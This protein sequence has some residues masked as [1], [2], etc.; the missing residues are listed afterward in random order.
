MTNLRTLMSTACLMMFASPVLAQPQAGLAPFPTDEYSYH[1]S[2]G[3]EPPPVNLPSDLGRR[4]GAVLVFRAGTHSGVGAATP[5]CD[6]ECGTQPE[7]EGFDEHPS[8]VLSSEWLTSLS[9]N[10]RFGAGL[11]MI[12]TLSTQMDGE[13]YELGTVVGGDLVFEGLIDLSPKIA[14]TLRGSAGLSLLFPSGDLD[15]DAQDL[16]DL[17]SNALDCQADPGPYL[18]AQAAV[19]AGLLYNLGSVGARVDFQLQAY[20]Y[21]VLGVEFGGNEASIRVAGLRPMVLAG[22][23]L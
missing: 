12:P 17:C 10:T 5:D 23:E 7:A 15:D 4:R 16:A 13:R 8:L 18:G 6:G 20:S 22:L 9:R 3:D 19:G 14:F 1:P 21:R 11:Q 2:T